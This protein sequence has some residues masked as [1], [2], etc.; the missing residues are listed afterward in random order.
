VSSSFPTPP[1]IITPY[2]EVLALL[3]PLETLLSLEFPRPNQQRGQTLEQFVEQAKAIFRVS[4]RISV[5][6]LAPAMDIGD[7]I[8]W[9]GIT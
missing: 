8:V 4:E 5:E 6:Y 1:I 2:Q 7:V 9:V 3:T